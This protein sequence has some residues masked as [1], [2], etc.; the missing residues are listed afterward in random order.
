METNKCDV[1]SMKGKNQ[2]SSNSLVYCFC[3]K[4]QL[5][6]KNYDVLC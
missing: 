4:G 1:A 5:H 2:E 3:V 6:V